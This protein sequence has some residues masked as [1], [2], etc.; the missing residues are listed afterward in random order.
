MTR[1]HRAALDHLGLTFATKLDGRGGVDV[2]VPF[3]PG[4]TFGETVA[5]VAQLSAAV[6]DAEPE[7]ADRTLVTHPVTE[8]GSAGYVAPYSPVA[9]PG[10]P[11]SAPMSWDELD[12]DTRPDPL[13]LDEVVQRTSRV[14]DLFATALEGGQA[15]PRLT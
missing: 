11:V 7:V 12:Q 15:L 14:G 8:P 2:V 9:D 1:L 3:D 6:A 10:A 13:S 5:W 4:P